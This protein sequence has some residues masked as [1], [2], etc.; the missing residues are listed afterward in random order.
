MM[1]LN[2]LFWVMVILFAIIG[3]SRGWAKELLV[4]FAVILGMFIITVL[5]RY[6]PFVRDNL[7][8]NP[9]AMVTVVWIRLT[10][11]LTLVFFGYQTPNLPRIASS[12]RFVRERLQDSLLG[13]FL[14]AVNGYFIFGTIWYFLDAAGYPFQMIQPPEGA[15]AEATARLMPLMPPHWMGTPMIYFAV[16]IA[17]AFI[18]VVLV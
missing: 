13:F 7:V 6:V 3:M 16:A 18:L 9:D 1:G 4:I 12:N 17:F 14:G 15:I 5:E 11:L 10:I 2:A 8:M